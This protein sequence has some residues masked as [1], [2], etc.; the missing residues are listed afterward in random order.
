M[1][2]PGRSCTVCMSKN[3]RVEAR[4]IATDEL[5]VSWYECGDHE[6]HDNVANVQRVSLTPID[7]WFAAI[8][9]SR[10]ASS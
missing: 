4:F 9:P 3:K 10:G 8:F 7:E 5:G 1:E 6:P 2:N